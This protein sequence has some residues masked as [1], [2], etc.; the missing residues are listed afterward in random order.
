MV[1]RLI[2]SLTLLFS[3]NVAYSEDAPASKN[4][5]AVRTTEAITIDGILSEHIWQRP[6]YTDLTQREP[7]QGNPGTEHS[8]IWLA[9][10]N[11]A[12]YLAAKM[13]D[14]SPDSVVARLVR[15]DF[16]Y[17]DPSDGM[18]FYLDPFNDHR[19]GF[20]FYVSAAGT[21]ADG[22][23]ENDG[24]FE[25]S[26]D[27]VWDGVAKLTPD[28]YVIEMRIPFSQLRFKDL[29]AQVWGFNFERYIG[30][31]NE[32]DLTVYTPRNE[33]GYVSRFPHIEGIEGIGQPART[34]VLPYVV[35][36]AEYI[37]ADP[38]NPFN[39]GQR[40][41]PG[42]GLDLKVGLGSALTLDATIN[43]D[44]GQVEV[45]PAVVNLS[46]VE[47]TYQEKRPFFLEGVSIFR[48]GRGGATNSWGFN[49]SPPSLFYSR[50]IGRAPQAT[51]RIYSASPDF[52]DISSGT[53][54]I[55]AGKVSGRIFDDWKIGAIQAVTRQEYAEIEVNGQR[56]TL[57]I[58]PLTSYSVLRLQ[59]DFNNGDQG[60]GLISTYTNRFFRDDA[61]KNLLNSNALVTA[62]DG[63][64]FLDGQRTYVVTGWAGVSNVQG[65]TARMIA[66]QRSSAHYFQR[67]DATYLG[68]DSAATSLTGYSGR[69]M[70]SKERGQL[71]LNAAVGLNSPKFESND[72]G[73]MAYSN[74][75]NAY[76][77]TGYRWLEP[78]EYYRQL[79]FDAATFATYDFGG[80][81]TN[82]GY[83]FQSN[84]TL[85]F[86]YYI[87]VAAS[88]NPESYSARRTRGGPLMLTP[89]STNFNVDFY[90]DNRE[91]W[92]LGAGGGSG[93][94]KDGGSI[95]MYA[96]LEL[97]VTPTLTLA[98]GPQY[99]KG[100]SN[101]FYA[102]SYGDAS[103]TE[104]FGRRYV[105]AIL[106]NTEL[107]ANLRANWILSPDLSF[108]IYLQPY[109][110]TGAYTDFK[111]L[112]KP[113]TY[114]FVV[115]TPAYNPDFR[116]A[117]LRGNAVLRWEYMPGSTL[118]LVWTQS[119]E[120]IESIG[121]F[122]FNHSVN[123]LFNH[124]RP[125]NI[126][127]LKF[128]YWLGM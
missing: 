60:L 3:W 115:E 31:K 107:S 118:F 80:N 39:S 73:Y 74:V 119:R 109:I 2:L 55:G 110:A 41:L 86:Y 18:V 117:S 46:D 81:K 116:Y 56:S 17:G 59:R 19:N 89:S 70:F 127:M 34:E 5:Q 44:F 25:L 79:G 22:V 47:V 69:L 104:T 124:T 30:R 128:S 48:F 96:S 87:G 64:A 101:A 42:A 106:T 125:D 62:A 77:V 88:Y 120:N 103:A 76:V 58:E 114:D 10:D 13:S 29:P 8:E 99:Y 66:L 71:T 7:D 75:I 4:V 63:W 72:L 26:W 93:T 82:H 65:N 113:K 36:K 67:P 24:A 61:L 1:R 32:T 98:I 83:Y 33:T 37:G 68:V 27:A 111:S 121:D 38:G 23:V 78:T 90:S 16:V 94:G 54:I 100:T 126:L 14:H 123:Q 112:A 40:Y 50:R 92:V 85:P 91:W 105:F 108:Q 84:L 53:R 45:D 15:R 95:N 21:K 97:K 49:W 57:E 35:G 52:A 43:P 20:L 28:G 6:G 9:Y 102:Y 51:S 12:I 122:E 11:E